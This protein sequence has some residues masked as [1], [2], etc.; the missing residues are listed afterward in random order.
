M[1]LHK[2]YRNKTRKLYRKKVRKRGLGSIEKYLIDYNI[3][4]KVDVIGDPSV[5]KRGLPHRRHYG[6]TGTVIGQKGRCYIVEVKLG[7]A[8]K[9]LIIG[10][11]HL[12]LNSASVKIK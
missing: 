1:T 4:D 12:R 2:G 6:K 3:N 7:N 9:I 11:E 10:R 5:H 8:K